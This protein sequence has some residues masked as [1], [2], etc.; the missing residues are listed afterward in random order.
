MTGAEQRRVMERF[1][2]IYILIEGAKVDV[3][4]FRFTFDDRLLATI[5]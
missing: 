1:S 3:F 4:C 2:K 5:K